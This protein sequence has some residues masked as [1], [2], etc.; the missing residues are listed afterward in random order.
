MAQPIVIEWDRDQI[1]AATGTASGKSVRIE[2]A[3]TVD[4]EGGTLNARELGEKLTEALSSA[5]MKA[6]E[7]VVVFPRDLVTFHRITLPNLG[8]DEIPELVRMQAATRLTVPV[9]SVCLDFVPL[10]AAPGA[11]TREVILVTLPQQHVTAVMEALS[12]CRLTLS[13][14]RVSSF[15]IAASAVN[16]GLVSSDAGSNVEAIIALGSDSIEMIFMNGNSVAFSHSGASWTSIEAAEQAVR[17]EVSRA[18]MAAAEDMGAYTVSRLTLIGSPEV[19]A[20][21][22]DSITKRLNDATVVRVDP[23]DTLVS[24]S[25][26]GVSASDLLAI[27]GALVAG[28]AASVQNVDLI[29]PRKAPEKKDYGRLKKILIG[30]GLALLVIGGWKYRDSAV[31]GYEKQTKQIKQDVADMGDR[32]KAAKNQLELAE[33]LKAWSNR[34]IGWLDQMVKIREIMGSTERV[35]IKDVKFQHLDSK[36][37][38]GSISANGLAK[39]RRDIEDLE[40][41]LREAGFDVT[42]NEMQQSLRDPDYSMEVEL[43]VRIPVPE[44]SSAAKA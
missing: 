44:E 8:D 3:V 43:D 30:G 14:V 37:H 16:A 40:R 28:R 22:P 33:D 4:R 6:E 10:P 15:G 12:T 23:N 39:S 18:R 34:D 19:T 25:F 41:R 32:Y 9:E 31:S 24:G 36:T 13:S 35:F 27:S 20:V 26:A 1:I 38:V 5:G 42:P 29:N 2:S 11:E 17:A 21:V 7:A